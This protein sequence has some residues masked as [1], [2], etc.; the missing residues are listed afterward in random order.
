[1]KNSSIVSSGP[2]DFAA[3]PGGAGFFSGAVGGGAGAGLAAAP[4]LGPGVK[5][6]CTLM[7]PSAARSTPPTGCL[8]RIRATRA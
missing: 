1:M 7:V 5:S 2:P 3:G 6:F 8:S 4:G